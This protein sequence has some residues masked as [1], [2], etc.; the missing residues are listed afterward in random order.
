MTR[1]Q[2]TGH[3]PRS[4]ERP[5]EITGI[6]IPV[7]EAQPY[8]SHPHITL[9]APFRPRDRLDDPALRRELE[10]FFARVAPISFALV[11]V[12]RF[13]VG[14][15][16]L[17]PEPAEP[18][19]AT[20]LALAREFPDCPPYEGLFDNVI[21]HVTIDNGARPVPLPIA[22]HATVAHLVY[23]HDSVWDI[24]AAFDLAG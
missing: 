2:D 20:T 3:V 9:L 12:R 14:I 7:P 24:V 11:Q 22:G 21:P 18:F 23:S 15:V 17:A 5:R 6:V 8:A 1:S 4:V 19:R 16:Y 10:A 13:P